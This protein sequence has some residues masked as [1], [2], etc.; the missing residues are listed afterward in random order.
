[1]LSIK[2]S[3]RVNLLLV[4]VLNIELKALL[5]L[6]PFFTTCYKVVFCLIER[7]A[8][9]CRYR[10]LRHDVRRRVDTAQGPVGQISVSRDDTVSHTNIHSLSYTIRASTSTH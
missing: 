2:V 8:L 10:R 4:S 6:L 1:M 7:L 5:V 3:N 9:A